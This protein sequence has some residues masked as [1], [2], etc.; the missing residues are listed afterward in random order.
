MVLFHTIKLRFIR[1]LIDINEKYIFEKRLR[2]FYK[3]EFKNGPKQVID[4]G[5]NKGQ[6]ID[7][8]L[9]L[10]PNCIIFGF[11]PN[12]TL[13]SQLRKKYNNYSNVKLFNLGISE[14][15]GEK[16]FHE[17]IL[18]YTS[19]FEELNFDS[20]YLKTKSKVLGVE[21]K[22]LIKGSYPVKVTTLSDFINSEINGP[23]DVLKIDTEGHEF[24]CL[25][26][27]FNNNLAQKIN[28][29]QLESHNDDMYLNKS[30][31]KIVENI[32]E[33]NDFKFKATVKHGFGNLDENI[34][35]CTL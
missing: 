2:K 26:G 32:L 21:P 19:T 35:Q 25:K 29:I 14:A 23:I 6:T 15:S 12:P 4:V 27:L 10:N 11:E 22:N 1:F 18:D 33:N 17:N 20:N 9:D 30:N 7:F 13:F 16:I 8:F 5:A 28:F 3:S 31:P 24:S 34:F